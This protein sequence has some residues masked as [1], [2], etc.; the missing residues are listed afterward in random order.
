MSHAAVL[1][2]MTVAGFLAWDLGQPDRHELVD[3]VPRAMTGARQRRDRVVVNVLATLHVQLRGRECRA[4][5]ADTAV[6]AGN[7]NVRRPD[8][9]VDC[10]PPDDDAL[11]AA[12]PRVLVEVLSPSTREFELIEKLEDYR[13]IAR[14]LAIL[15]VDPDEARVSLWHREAAGLGWEH[16]VLR[17]RD[18]V[19]V[20]PAVG[21][22]LPLADN[23]AGLPFRA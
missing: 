13:G 4:F 16:A 21:L 22:A 11:S 15:L 7:G 1:T 10:G 9:G 17:G 2:G 8:A 12:D 20:L 3:G 19:V 5:T 14:L 6:V 23:Y 18:T